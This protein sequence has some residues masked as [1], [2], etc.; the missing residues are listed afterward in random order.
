MKYFV[1]IAHKRISYKISYTP[2]TATLAIFSGTR[3]PNGVV[4]HIGLILG[5][6]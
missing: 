3:E 2:L 5:L 6:L 1:N 4:C